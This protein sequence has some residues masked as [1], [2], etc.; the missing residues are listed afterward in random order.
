MKR[1]SRKLLALLMACCLCVGVIPFALATETG[2]AGEQPAFAVDTVTGKQGDEVKVKVSMRNNPGVAILQIK[3][4]YD[5]DALTLVSYERGDAMKDASF[6]PGQHLDDIPFNCLWSGPVNRY[7][8]GVLVTFTFK[9]KEDAAP[10]SSAV[11]LTYSPDNVINQDFE[12]VTFAVEN[13]GVTVSCNHTAGAWEVQTAATC[14]QP[15]TEIQKCTKCGEAVN[16]RTIEAT[17][18]TAGAWEVQTAPT[19]TQPGTEIQKCT[20]CGATV[21]TKEIPATGHTFGEWET[22]TS[23]TCTDQGSEQRTCEV[24]GFTETRDIDPLGH[25]WESEYTIDKEATCTEDGSKSIHCAVCDA[26]KDSQVIPATGHDYTSEVV[27][28][29]TCTESGL[30]H[31]ICTVCGHEEDREIPATGHQWGEWIVDKEAAETE[32]GS[33]HRECTACGA[34][35][36]ETIPVITPEPTEPAAPETDPTEQPSVPADTDNGSNTDTDVPATGDQLWVVSAVALGAAGAAAI[37]L[38]AKRRRK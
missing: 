23:P 29:P 27:Q 7:G 5:K 6:T 1:H 25:Q 11:T 18:H 4:S 26:V 19:C 10:G 24:C 3:M 33:R 32:E 15:G 12:E 16:S 37:A 38:M 13:G 31:L 36:T 9:I 34:V 20:V 2:A 17:G 35:E 22:I 8:D 21:N 14:T 28:E 30:E